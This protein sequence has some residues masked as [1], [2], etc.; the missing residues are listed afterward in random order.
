MSKIN[1]ETIIMAGL[2]YGS[3]YRSNS[4]GRGEGVHFIESINKWIVRV[5][6]AARNG[7]TTISAHPTKE[8]ADE[9][10]QSYIEKQTKQL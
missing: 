5:E 10:Y 8:L 6:R 4:R 9:A 3:K 1:G 2:N 7:N